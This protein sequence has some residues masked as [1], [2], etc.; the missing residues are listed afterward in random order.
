[1]ILIQ[2]KEKQKN[3]IV[4]EIK[5]KQIKQEHKSNNMTPKKFA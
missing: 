1:M 4:L 3:A 2:E 5:H